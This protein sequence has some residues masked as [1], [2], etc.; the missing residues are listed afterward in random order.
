MFVLLV[1]SRCSY[2]SVYCVEFDSSKIIT[3]SRDRTI[4]VWSLKT[5]RCLATFPGHRGSVLCLK[6]ELDFDLD[7]AHA[8]S[9]R[10]PDGWHKGLMVSGS[11]DCS[12][13]VWDLYC[14]PAG[15]N[16]EIAITAEM[17]GI[18]YGHSGG[19]LDL[20]IEKNWIISWYVANVAGVIYD[21]DLVAA[22]KTRPSSCGIEAPCDYIVHSA[23]MKD[24]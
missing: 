22:V 7:D 16:E 19:V 10:D 12:V 24:L 1:Y 18:L 4:K 3:G 9:E 13:G 20:R 6:F 15:D 8:M 21:A 2:H 5:G 23:A 11:S 17:R 14:H